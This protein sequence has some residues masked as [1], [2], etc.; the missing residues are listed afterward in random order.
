MRFPFMNLFRQS[1][2]E[3]SADWTSQNLPLWRETLA[4]VAGR[5]VQVLEIGSFEGRSAL[6]FLDYLSQSHV[7][8]IDA[9]F[10]RK[11]RRRFL[12]NTRPYGKRVRV[13]RMLSLGGL[14]RLTREGKRYDVVY[15]D[16]SHRRAD[17]LSDS[18][19]AW[20]LLNKQGLLIWDDYQWEP[21]LPDHER[22]KQA[23][24][25]FLMMFAGCF[26]EVHRGYQILVRKTAEWPA[27]PHPAELA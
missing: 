22:P 9:F 17:V 27:A 23:I 5:P 11:Y 7:T 4:P 6:F 12:A 14:A 1:R 21:K 25:L 2:P 15:I 24:D 19:A 10:S 3:F 18:V 26:D 13:L 20:P 8:C 16:G